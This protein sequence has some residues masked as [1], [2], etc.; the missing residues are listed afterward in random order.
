[1]SHDFCQQISWKIAK[2]PSPIIDIFF[3]TNDV[4]LGGG[5]G[6]GA[7]SFGRKSALIFFFGLC[8]RS[9]PAAGAGGGRA[10]NYATRGW[11][12]WPRPAAAVIH[13]FDLQSWKFD[14]DTLTAFV[15]LR[16]L[17][18]CEAWRAIRAYTVQSERGLHSFLPGEVSFQWS[19][20]RSIQATLTGRPSRPSR[21]MENRRWVWK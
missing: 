13:Q 20:K 2:G 6:V 7:C 12:I 18:Y 9:S 21:S 11:D 4:R 17:V 10:N 16:Q 5:G 3:Q 1:M 14:V 8:S 19:M 15:D